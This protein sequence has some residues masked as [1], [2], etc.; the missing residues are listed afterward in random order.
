MTPVEQQIILYWIAVGFYVTSATLYM[1]SLVFNKERLLNIAML[2]NL[3]G[4]VPHTVAL[5]MRWMETGHFP[6]WGTYEV[7]STYAWGAVFLLL[8]TQFIKPNLKIVGAFIMPFVF[9]MIGIAVMS[10]TLGTPIPRT[11][12]TFWLGV[13]IAFAQLSYGSALIAAVLAAAY[14]MTAKQRATGKIHPLLAKLPELERID[15]LSYRLTIFAFTML[16]AM[17]A[18]GAVWAYKAWGRYWGWDPIETW[19][20]VS[21]LVYGLYLH[22]RRT[23]GWQGKRASWLN[24]FALFL[25]IFAFFGIP[26]FYPSAHEHLEY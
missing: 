2:S 1:I 21:W 10:P 14:L 11:Y 17:I 24:I 5:G 19:A 20:L 23:M 6:Y 18:S 15:F 12:F 7:F 22:L 3:I 26:L 4:L 8:L 16:G 9:L 13:H 25:I